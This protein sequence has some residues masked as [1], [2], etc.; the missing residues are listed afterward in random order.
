MRTVKENME[1]L[2]EHAEDIIEQ[3]SELSGEMISEVQNLRESLEEASQTASQDKRVMLDGVRSGVAE[4]SKALTNESAD[5]F[6]AVIS[7]SQ[8]LSEAIK[9]ITD[10]QVKMANLWQQLILVMFMARKSKRPV[11]R[12]RA[13]DLLAMNGFNREKGAV[14]LDWLIETGIIISERVGAGTTKTL[15]L[16]HEDPNLK[17]ALESWEMGEEVHYLF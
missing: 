10:P 17:R 12:K 13:I 7:A 14:M 3:N 9:S 2:R 1:A 4:L 16:N 15:R 5:R 8:K 6:V 11:T